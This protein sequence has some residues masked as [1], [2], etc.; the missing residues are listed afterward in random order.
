MV[1]TTTTRKSS[2]VTGSWSGQWALDLRSALRVRRIPTMPISVVRMGQVHSTVSGQPSRPPNGLV[3]Q[4][5]I[6]RSITKAT[7]SGQT[8]GLQRASLP[9]SSRARLAPSVAGATRTWPLPSGRPGSCTCRAGWSCSHCA[10]GDS[11]ECPF[12]AGL[13]PR[14]RLAPRRRDSADTSRRACRAPQSGGIVSVLPL[15]PRFR[16]SRVIREVVSQ[17]ESRRATVL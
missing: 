7:K 4:P 3:Y 9:C 15:R 17:T 2:H 1:E 10:A 5:T 12:A 6:T 14:T 8:V 13:S 11:R 16:R